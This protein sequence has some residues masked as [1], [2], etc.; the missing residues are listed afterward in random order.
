MQGAQVQSLIGELRTHML[1]GV[2][3][4]KKK[5]QIENKEEGNIYLTL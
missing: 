5:K 1:H 3:K 2:A 4:K